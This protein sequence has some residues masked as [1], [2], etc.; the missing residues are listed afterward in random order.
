MRFSKTNSNDIIFYQFQPTKPDTFPDGRIYYK[1]IRFP[2]ETKIIGSL[3]F[4]PIYETTSEACVMHF[5]YEF[6]A[7]AKK[8]IGGKKMCENSGGE[9]VELLKTAHFPYFEES[10]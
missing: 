3:D 6:D 2:S 1:N 5:C 8:I 4:T 9:V 7:G 10:Q